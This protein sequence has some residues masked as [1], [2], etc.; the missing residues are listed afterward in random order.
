MVDH[1]P[2]HGT[3]AGDGGR[4]TRRCDVLLVKGVC[5]P[6]RGHNPPVTVQMAGFVPIHLSEMVGLAPGRRQL[7]PARTGLIRPGWPASG[8]A[9]GRHFCLLS[10]FGS[11][12]DCH[13]PFPQGATV[14]QK[15]D[16]PPN[17]QQLRSLPSRAVSRSRLLIGLLVQISALFCGGLPGLA[18]PNPGAAC[19]SKFCYNGIRTLEKSQKGSCR[20]RRNS[21]TKGR[22]GRVIRN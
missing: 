2:F 1:L 6:P 16:S 17:S 22:S 5:P 21:R 4:G 12:Q 8:C 7:G 19:L 20:D 3:R 9:T 11:R 14:P 13:F 15:M 18:W 10:C